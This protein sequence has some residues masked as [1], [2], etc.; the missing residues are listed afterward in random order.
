M[1]PLG[2]AVHTA[3]AFDLIGEDVLITGAGPIGIM[4]AAIARHVGARHVVLTDVNDFRLALAERVTDVRTVNVS[5]EDLKDVALGLGMKEGFD[6][7]L[8][9]S[10]APA[11]LP[12]IVDNMIM[13]GRIALLGIPPQKTEVDWSPIIMK[14][15]TL[16]AIYGRQMFETWY[17]MLSM[18]ESGLDISNVITHRFSFDAFQDGFDCARSGE[19]GKVILDWAA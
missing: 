13:G 3:L 1:D 12:Q 8:E 19:S 6:I 14:A 4:A 9:M 17:K 5:R 15:L 10:G 7:A 18:L 2:N 16:K 11:A